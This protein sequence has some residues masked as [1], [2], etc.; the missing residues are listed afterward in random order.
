MHNTNS[1]TYGKPHLGFQKATNLQNGGL[2]YKKHRR[3]EI[4]EL[5]LV[6]NVI[7]KLLSCPTRP[8]KCAL[9]IIIQ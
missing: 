7:A 5:N 8:A 9:L 1:L 6:E 4:L 2:L 3:H